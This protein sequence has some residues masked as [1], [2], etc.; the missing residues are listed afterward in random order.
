LLI[1]TY[2]TGYRTFTEHKYKYDGG[3]FVGHKKT[4]TMVENHAL[5]DAFDAECTHLDT[6]IP[7]ARAAHIL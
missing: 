2:E 3:A 7:V 4:G 5:F 6:S 1:H